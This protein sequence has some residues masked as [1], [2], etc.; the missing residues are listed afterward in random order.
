MGES[1]Q[2]SPV[3]ERAPLYE[4]TKCANAV[5]VVEKIT[6]R[7]MQCTFQYQCATCLCNSARDTEEKFRIAVPK[8]D[9]NCLILLLLKRAEFRTRRDRRGEKLNRIRSEAGMNVAD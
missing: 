7:V 6:A 8:F 2:G 1:L 9:L 5:M 4:T 3:R